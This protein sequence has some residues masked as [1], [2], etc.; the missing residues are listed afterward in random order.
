MICIDEPSLMT[1]AL[2]S[3]PRFL[4]FLPDF[5]FC[6]LIS[7]VGSVF[8]SVFACIVLV[9]F[10][11]AMDASSLF[12][13]SQFGHPKRYEEP[14]ESPD[15]A[16]L[17][18]M[19]FQYLRE[20]PTKSS[21]P[22][23]VDS[24]I[25]TW[26]A[27]LPDFQVSPIVTEIHTYTEHDD[28][29][30]HSSSSPLGSMFS[31]SSSLNDSGGPKTPPLTT[32]VNSTIPRPARDDELMF[33]EM[34][35]LPE[36]APQVNLNRNCSLR[37]SSEV[38][39]SPSRA[40]ST[41]RRVS[42]GLPSPSS[43]AIERAPIPQ[44]P[45]AHQRM[46]ASLTNLVS[47]PEFVPS[48]SKPPV[49]K[50]PSLPPQLRISTLSSDPSQLP[51]LVHPEWELS[52]PTTRPTSAERKAQKYQDQARQSAP[53][54]DHTKDLLRTLEERKI[55]P[56]RR[57][58]AI[59]SASLSS[60][61][62]ESMNRLKASRQ[63]MQIQIPTQ[64]QRH[65]I[66]EVPVQSRAQRLTG[67]EQEFL[68]S[69]E[70]G[71]APPTRHSIQIPALCPTLR[72]P[73]FPA[74]APIRKP[75]KAEQ[76]I[77]RMQRKAEIEKVPVQ[78]VTSVAAARAPIN[79]GVWFTKGFFAGRE[80]MQIKMTRR[81]T[82]FSKLEWVIESDDGSKILK[83]FGHSNSLSRK[84]DFADIDDTPIFTFQKKTG[85]TM[86]AE[87]PNGA[88]LFT[89][90]N[91]LYSSPFWTLNLGSDNATNGAAQWT[92]KGDS[93]LEAV[94]V[95]WGGFQV[96]RISL[97]SKAKK[98]TYILNIAPEV[99]YCIIAALT[100]VFDD[101]RT[102]GVYFS[103]VLIFCV[104]VKLDDTQALEFPKDLGFG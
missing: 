81:V 26:A 28:S 24:K 68:K 97:E 11:T 64:I 36:P 98:H 15:S 35:K 69:L 87:A 48:P 12:H 3:S 73:E 99:N 86:V 80:G 62:L 46:Q 93:S 51:P 16:V 78:S 25:Q 1:F 47:L 54:P 31:D 17:M 90:R 79:S 21:L 96:G 20:D 100:T 7:S 2:P 6:I 95:S 77:T 39:R 42:F 13:V 10:F 91:T 8:L 40:T 75:V 101:L 33:P 58:L 55:S 18:D 103:F 76:S 71:K 49:N 30:L 44:I 67:M 22:T 43:P 32:N 50:K 19:I 53:V 61:R 104:S 27:S 45:A 92:A 63:S 94:A 4:L 59:T 29:S 85:S 60:S 84:T 34:P 74:H 65:P 102:V 38:V 70:G 14:V 41:S 88:A 83:S 82:K 89:I 23:P 66:Q 5:C 72:T 9:H 56:S 52:F 37:R 57:S